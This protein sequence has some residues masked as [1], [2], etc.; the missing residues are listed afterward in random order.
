MLPEKFYTNWRHIVWFFLVF[1]FFAFSS[2]VLII[3]FM[4]LCLQIMVWIMERKILGMMISLNYLKMVFATMEKAMLPAK[5]RSLKNW[6]TS[7]N[8][9]YTVFNMLAENFTLIYKL[10][11]LFSCNTVVPKDYWDRKNFQDMGP[12]SVNSI[13]IRGLLFE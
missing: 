9:L 13:H 7:F 3:L 10:S 2:S 1:I 8:P 4:T 5:K 11:M 6:L 12:L